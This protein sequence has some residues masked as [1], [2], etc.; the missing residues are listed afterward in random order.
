MPDNICQK[1]ISHNPS[2]LLP[3]LGNINFALADEACP[4]NY[5]SVAFVGAGKRN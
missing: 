5:T 3:Q 4:S 2:C 1:D